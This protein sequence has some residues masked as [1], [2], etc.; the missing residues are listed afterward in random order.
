MDN[1]GI[2]WRTE[3][4]GDKQMES[5]ELQIGLHGHKMKCFLLVE[6]TVVRRVAFPLEQSDLLVEWLKEQTTETLKAYL[7]LSD[8]S[9]MRS[10]LELAAVLAR[11]GITTS[12]DG[13]CRFSPAHKRLN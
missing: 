9:E 4:Q 11:A 13:I 7:R 8:G 12:V 1:S 2:G 10:A 3:I 6:G 5:T